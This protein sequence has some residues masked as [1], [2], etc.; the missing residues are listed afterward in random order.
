MRVVGGTGSGEP[1]VFM[2]CFYVMSW[3]SLRRSSYAI[4]SGRRSD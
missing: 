4:W 2:G 3:L 1:G